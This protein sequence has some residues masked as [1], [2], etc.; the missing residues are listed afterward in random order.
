MLPANER[1]REPTMNAGI[2]RRLTVQTLCAVTLA[3][4][5]PVVAFAAPPTWLPTG[6]AGQNSVRRVEELKSIY[7]ECDRASRSNLLDAGSAGFCSTSAEELR[8]T[9][10]D[11]RFE[12]L[13][14]WWRG[15]TQKTLASSKLGSKKP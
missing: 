10:F 7:L 6:S 9:G 2:A 13:F 4:G 8:R 5:F 1:Y 14:A 11:G 3:T 12:D 15:A